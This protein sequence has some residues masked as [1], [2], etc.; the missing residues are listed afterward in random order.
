MNKIDINKK[1]IIDR[2]DIWLDVPQIN[3]EELSSQKPSGELSQKIRERVLSARQ[4]QNKSC[5]IS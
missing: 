5:P 1:L 4:I 3:H 2:I